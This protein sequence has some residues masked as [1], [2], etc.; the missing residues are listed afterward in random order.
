MAAFTSRE[1]SDRDAFNAHW[2]RILKDPLNVCKTIDVDGIAVGNLLCFPLFGK[3]SVGYWI[4]KEFWGKGIATAAL[5]T[6]L[7]ELETRPLYAAAAADNAGSI[8]VLEKCGF[9]IYGSEMGYA[10][11]RK[12]EIK[13]VLLRLD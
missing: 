3:I 7:E 8:R 13:E 4:G 2:E 5:K 12:E 10:N 11:A 1:P 9:V 6:F